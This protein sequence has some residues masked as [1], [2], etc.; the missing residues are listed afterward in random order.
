MSMLGL[1]DVAKS[2]GDKVLFSD[3]TITLNEGDRVGLVGANGGGKSTL[4]RV[5]A[6]TEVPDR[7]DRTI[8]RG[9]SFGYLSQDPVVDPELTIMQA[10]R[11]GLG[12]RGEVLDQLA[13]IHEQLADPELQMKEMERLLA[14]SGKLDAELDALGGHDVDHKVSALITELGLDREDAPAETTIC[15]TLSGGE[16]RRVALARLLLADPDVMLLDEP[17]NHLDAIVIDWLEDVLA[18][19]RT[20]LVMVTHDRYFLDRVTTRI[21]E[22]DGGEIHA[23]EGGYA[24]FLVG[25]AERLARD[26]KEESTRLNILRRETEWMRRGPPARTTKSKS[27]VARYQALADS[28][29]DPVSRELMFEIPPGPRL[30]SRVLRAT[31]ITKSFGD[32]VVL[33]ALNLEIDAGT[34]VGIVGPNGAGK[35]TLVNLLMGELQPDSGEVVQGSTV[36]FAAIDQKRRDLDNSKTVLEE[37]SGGNDYVAV[38]DRMMRIETFLEQFLFP[39]Q[40][41]HTMVGKLSG[42]ER[43]RVLLAKLLSA[44][45]NVLVLDEPTN[46]LDLTTLRV[47]EEALMAFPGAVIAVSHDRYF[48][49]RIATRIIALDGHGGMRVHEGDLSGLLEKMGKERKELEDAASKVKRSGK[50]KSTKPSSSK[51]GKATKKLSTREREELDGLPRQIE[52]GEA[53]LSAMDQRLGDPELWSKPASAQSSDPGTLQADRE[54]LAKQIQG[55]YARWEELE[56]RSNRS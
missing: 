6:G 1:Q 50:S 48:L 10:I 20:T 21:L 53:R 28:A 49:D 51:S 2:F 37:V 11:E 22:I 52:E 44:G 34:R 17:T 33:P 24:D 8:R 7:G 46:D 55:Y 30:G 56:A 39:G 47:L 14:K 19:T 27:R 43:N 35:T 5:L 26:L 31:D 12:R 23:Y 45:G 40:S 3:V 41:K 25:R 54:N 42:G 13:V 16:R 9:I 32:R 29:P 36:K 15:A 38:G 4:M 18:A